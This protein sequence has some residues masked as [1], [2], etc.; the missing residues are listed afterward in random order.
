MT[1]EMHGRKKALSTHTAASKL[2]EI[3][4]LSIQVT[5]YDYTKEKLHN[6]VNLHDTPCPS[7][8]KQ[9]L[10]HGAGNKLIVCSGVKR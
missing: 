2:L 5:R 10:T 4:N 6:L 9:T 3:I 8:T 7:T 1:L